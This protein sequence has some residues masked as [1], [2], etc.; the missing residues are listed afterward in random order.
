MAIRISAVKSAHLSEDKKEIIVGTTSKYTGDL[1]LRFGS[2]CVEDLINAFI[3]A[4]RATQ[5]PTAVTARAAPVGAAPAKC[6]EVSSIPHQVRFEIPR[7]CTITADSGRQLV[8][9]VVNHKLD[10]QA[11]YAF[12]PDA[13]KQL[14]VGLVKSAD[15][16]LA[17]PAVASTS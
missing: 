7:N 15:A 12:S 6:P 1:E 5:P 4:L 11:G 2:E 17:Q 3:N 16:L 14:A 10:R 13:A 8:L 9:F